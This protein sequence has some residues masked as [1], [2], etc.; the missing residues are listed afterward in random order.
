LSGIF[1][2][3]D[4]ARHCRAFSMGAGRKNS[5]RLRRHGVVMLLGVGV[6]WRF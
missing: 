4:K 1:D 5:R 2:A 3:L 6:G